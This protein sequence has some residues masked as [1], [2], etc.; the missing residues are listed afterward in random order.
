MN[1]SKIKSINE[2]LDSIIGSLGS[3]TDA[4]CVD[5]RTKAQALKEQLNVERTNSELNIDVLQNY[6]RDNNI[7]VR[8]QLQIDD[9]IGFHQLGETVLKIVLPHRFVQRQPGDNSTTIGN[10]SKMLYNNIE[11]FNNNVNEFILDAWAV[12]MKVKLPKKCST[13]FLDNLFRELESGL[14]KI[15]EHINPENLNILKNLSDY[16]YNDLRTNG[17]RKSNNEK[18]E[19]NKTRFIID[20][21]RILKENEGF[22]KVVLEKKKKHFHLFFE[23]KPTISIEVPD[24]VLN[25]AFWVR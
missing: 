18:E 13:E 8:R 17:R 5:M 20:E 4:N 9:N 10:M 24:Y 23:S 1:Y 12:R 7:Q 22:G 2:S 21:I 14:V 11:E 19:K 16:V 25:E 6:F 15:P 3:E